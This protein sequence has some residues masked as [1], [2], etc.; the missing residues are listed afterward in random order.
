V[1]A[2]GRLFLLNAQ[3][4]RH[5]REVQKLESDLD[6]AKSHIMRLARHLSAANSTY[7]HSDEV[8]EDIRA[9]MKFTNQK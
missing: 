4:G 5:K 6:A 1:K 8:S 2:T 3:E 7:L 9:A